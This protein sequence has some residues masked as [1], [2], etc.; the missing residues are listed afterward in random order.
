MILLA[1]MGLWQLAAGVNVLAML[2]WV[3]FYL[4]FSL[5]WRRAWR[6]LI[7]IAVV[8]P[9]ILWLH[10]EGPDPQAVV[11]WMVGIVMAL[12]YSWLNCRSDL[13]LRDN[14]GADPVTSAYQQA[15]LLYD[16]R[17]EVPR[18]DRHNTRLMLALINQPTSWLGQN[19]KER[20]QLSVMLGSRLAEA[21][22]PHQSLYLLE[23]GN[24]VVLMPHA[25]QT[26]IDALSAALPYCLMLDEVQAALCFTVLS[27]RA[28]DD[29]T[30]LFERL[31]ATD[32]EEAETVR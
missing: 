32:S 6:L 17:R 2:Y 23:S 4:A 25:R 16:L 1:L 31:L 18:A 27:Y 28:D 30:S 19:D 7:A 21:M 29:A 3:P 11:T 22:L 14:L 5:G 20:R 24:F 12:M 9:M 10:P 15:Q 26:D 13:A 8:V